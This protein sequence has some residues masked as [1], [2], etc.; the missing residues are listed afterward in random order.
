[1]KIYKDGESNKEIQDQNWSIWKKRGW[2]NS[3]PK[4]GT[5]VVETA[6][7]EGGEEKAVKPK[8]RSRKRSR[9][10]KPGI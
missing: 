4:K 3:K 6:A 9:K 7:I 10:P 1:M 2:S 5:P 8:A